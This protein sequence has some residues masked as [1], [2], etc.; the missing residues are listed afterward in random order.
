MRR[1]IILM[2]AVQLMNYSFT[3][4]LNPKVIDIHR[5]FVGPEVELMVVLVALVEIQRVLRLHSLQPVQKTV[6]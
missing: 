6:G 5:T 3:K 2:H 1:L 4:S